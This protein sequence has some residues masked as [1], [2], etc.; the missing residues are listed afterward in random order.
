[1]FKVLT[2]VII[3]CLVLSIALHTMLLGFTENNE[4]QQWV[5]AQI[6]IQLA[7]VLALFFVKKF[8]IIPLVIFVILSVVFVYINAI[9][10]NYGNINLHL[11]L[12]PMFWVVYG[13]ILFNA[14]VKFTLRGS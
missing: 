7:G 8:K 12:F 10:V 6:F 14:K 13:R 9:Y 2:N 3:G 1:M 4:Y 11:V 5:Y